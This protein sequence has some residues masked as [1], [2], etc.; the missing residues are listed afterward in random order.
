MLVGFIES[1][2]KSG[3]LVSFKAK[4][5]F[6]KMIKCLSAQGIISSTLEKEL[7]WLREQRNNIHLRRV[8]LQENDREY[9]KY[10]FQEYNR[11]RDAVNNLNDV[12]LKYFYNQI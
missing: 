7:N 8:S 11:A 9:D 12:L 5:S 4:D 6:Y 3:K 1:L 2:Q 10:S